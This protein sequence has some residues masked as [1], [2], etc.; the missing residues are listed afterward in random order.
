M[1]RIRFSGARAGSLPVALTAT[2]VRRKLIA[3]LVTDRAHV[4][5]GRRIER[6]IDTLPFDVAGTFDGD[7]SCVELE[8]G[9]SEYVVCDL[10]SGLRLSGRPRSGTATGPR[11]RRFIICSSRHLHLDHVMGLPFFGRLH[12]GNRLFF[13][14]RIGSRG[15]VRRQMEPPSFPVESSVFNADIESCPCYPTG[16]TTSAACR[17]R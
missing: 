4:R 13:L 16:R 1:P 11:R 6:D 5:L 10:G 7:T 8:T 3:A 17:S 2:A 14:R 9:E 15:G 12:S